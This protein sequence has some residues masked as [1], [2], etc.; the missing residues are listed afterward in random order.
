[1]Y[2]YNAQTSMEIDDRLCVR[3]LGEE[4]RPITS[5]ICGAGSCPG[6][7][8]WN[9]GSFGPVSIGHIRRMMRLLL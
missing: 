2:C 7:F 6:L 8:A 4:R 5:Q 3:E 1:M 9:A